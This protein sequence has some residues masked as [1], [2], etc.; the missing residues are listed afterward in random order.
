MSKSFKQLTELYKKMD[1]K[2]DPHIGL[3][4]LKNQLDCDLLRDFLDNPEEYG[5]ELEDGII[6]PQNIVT[7][8]ITP[9]RIGMGALYDDYTALF[10]PQKNL[11]KEPLNY[12]IKEV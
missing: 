9:P 8:Y 6:S 1:F 10:Y 5:I 7:L 11:Y 3:L 2:E 12:Y 4:L